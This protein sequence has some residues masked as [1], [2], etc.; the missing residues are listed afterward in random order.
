MR[1]KQAIMEKLNIV[2]DN[3]DKWRNLPDYQMERR[4]DIFFS[5]YLK[6]VLEK[7][8]SVRLCE[9]LVPEFP[10]HKGT[11]YPHMKSNL[12]YKIDYLAV[13]TDL[14][15]AFLV[16][17]KTD[18]KSRRNSQDDYLDRAKEVGLN[19]LLNG[20]VEIF[21]A[22]KIKMKY[23]QLLRLLEKIGL[24]TVPPQIHEIVRS[25]SLRGISRYIS[26]ISIQPGE[27][28]CKI[29][30]VQPLGDGD[31][32]IVSLNSVNIYR[33]MMTTSREDLES[34]YLFGLPKRL[35][36]ITINSSIQI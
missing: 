24:V 14:R 27:S 8:Y 33:I 30:Y 35:V 25:N 11:I 29:A 16:E 9:E 31:D 23:Y 36:T 18:P 3:L 34:H 6:E 21:Q 22:S 26:S 15:S 1:A 5:V 4:A 19:K 32:V 13:T 17:L 12:S 28:D 2:F 20:L 7:K 10:I